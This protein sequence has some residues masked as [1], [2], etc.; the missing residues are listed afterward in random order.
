MNSA[1]SGVG[2]GTRGVNPIGMIV[3]LIRRELGKGSI[4]CENV[5]R[6]RIMM[7]GRVVFCAVRTA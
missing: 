2:S 4:R 3:D 1:S 5:G 6:W 7:A